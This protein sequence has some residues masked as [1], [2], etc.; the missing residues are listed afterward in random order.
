MIRKPATIDLGCAINELV[1]YLGIT[2]NTCYDHICDVVR[3][4]PENRRGMWHAIAK[5]L[6][7]KHDEVGF[8]VW[9]DRRSIIVTMDEN[10][11]YRVKEQKP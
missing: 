10:G 6:Y 1:S 3:E 9:K 5:V 2:R 4:E 8:T 7:W 11:A